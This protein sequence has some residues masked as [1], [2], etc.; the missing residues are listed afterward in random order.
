[1][2]TFVRKLGNNNVGGSITDI[3]YRM[4]YMFADITF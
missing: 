3:Y 1:M 2:W 4:L